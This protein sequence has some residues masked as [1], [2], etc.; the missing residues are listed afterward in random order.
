MDKT[1]N[2][3]P[4][5]MLFLGV[6][7]DG[8]K[9]AASRTGGMYYSFKIYDYF[10]RLPMLRV[11]HDAL[12]KMSARMLGRMTK[13]RFLS[14]YLLIMSRCQRYKYIFLSGAWDCPLFLLFSKLR[15]SKIVVFWFHRISLQPELGS[16]DRFI[17][18]FKEWCQLKF[19]DR[20]VVISKS[21]LNSIRE[22]GFVGDGYVLAAPGLDKDIWVDR[23]SG[24][25]PSRPGFRVICAASITPHKGIMDLLVAFADFVDTIGD[26]EERRGIVLDIVGNDQLDSALTLELNRVIRERGLTNN[27]FL[28]GRRSLQELMGFY[29]AASVFV[30]PSHYEGYGIVVLEAASFGLPIIVS[31]GGSLPEVVGDGQYGLVYPVGDRTALMRQIEL[32]Y[33]DVAL[34]GNLSEKADELYHSA[35]TWEESAKLI[36]AYLDRMEDA[37]KF[38][39]GG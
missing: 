13:L 35:I 12:S 24:Y 21:A 17:W 37:L 19:S 6:A 27:A 23:S 25:D 39:S 11:D 33:R 2:C 22:L 3:K 31:N 9:L 7:L 28:R 34:R 29:R 26:S 8:T 18:R 20:V 36:E 30:H 1:S 38:S 10:R 15:G 5:S 14:P 16:K 32:V 4:V